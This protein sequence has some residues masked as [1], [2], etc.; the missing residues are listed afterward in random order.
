MSQ[1]SYNNERNRKDAVVGSTR[2]SAASAKPVRKKGTVDVTKAGTTKR[3]KPGV[4][5][6]WAGLPTSPE[7]KKWRRVWWVLLLGGIGAV[8]LG[9]LEPELR[10]NESVQ[11]IIA[12]LVLAAS[13][14][15]VTIDLVVIRRLR[16]QLIEAQSKKPSKKEQKHAGDVQG[17]KA[18]GKD[19][20]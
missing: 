9:Y 2:K 18:S 1:R 10:A 17:A 11:R 16:K 4:E 13:M 12:M 5:K 7:I 6:D 3:A 8:A 19:K 14:A 15:A 20:A